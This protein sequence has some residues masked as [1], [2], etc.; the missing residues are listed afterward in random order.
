MVGDGLEVVA[1]LAETEPAS[2]DLLFVDA[3]SGDASQAMTCPPSTFLAAT[4]LENARRLLVSNGLL[5]VNCVSRQ[6]SAVDKAIHALQVRFQGC[7]HRV[8][9][10]CSILC[11]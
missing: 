6:S 7:R 4:F 10:S 11:I 3:N 9:S 5:V 8:Q 2:C 1:S